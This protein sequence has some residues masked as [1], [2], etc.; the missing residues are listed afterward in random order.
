MFY[1]YIDKNEKI[2]LPSRGSYTNSLPLIIL[3]I[4][5]VLGCMQFV[6]P[7]INPIPGFMFNHP[8]FAFVIQQNIYAVNIQH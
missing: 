2:G 1:A 3:S 5:F 8:S 7:V 4:M 6:F